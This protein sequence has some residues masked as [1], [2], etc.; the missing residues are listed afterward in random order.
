MKKTTEYDLF[1]TF[2][3]ECT[4]ED[5]RQIIKKAVAQAKEGEPAARLFVAA[6]V[7]GTPRSCNLTLSGV[8][9]AER[10]HESFSEMENTLWPEKKAKGRR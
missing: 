7:L 8:D 6:Y 5:F 4:A 9:L 3:D 10:Q 1:R 2:R